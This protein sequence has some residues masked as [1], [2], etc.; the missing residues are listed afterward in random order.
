[1][2]FLVLKLVVALLLGK[3][4]ENIVQGHLRD[5]KVFQ[6]VGWVSFGRLQDLE[7]PRDD[8]W[9]QWQLE[10]ELVRVGLLEDVL[11]EVSV[12]QAPDRVHITH[13]FGPHRQ[14]VPGT[15]PEIILGFSF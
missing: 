15:E 10:E 5:G 7:D 8:P 1:M 9:H 11:G 2:K 4:D 14:S 12:H 13:V 6:G 3:L